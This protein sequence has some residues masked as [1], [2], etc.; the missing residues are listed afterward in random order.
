[1][2]L[3][4]VGEWSAAALDFVF[5]P[6]CLG[7]GDSRPSQN[8]LCELCGKKISTLEHPLCLDCARPIETGVNCPSCRPGMPLFVVGDH[9]GALQQMVI[10]F[11]FRQVRR[12]GHWAAVELC[13]R[14]RDRIGLLDPSALV[15]VP[16]H[17]RREYFRGFNQAE[18]FAQELGEMLDL[19]VRCDL[20]FRKKH[21]A[22]QSRISG[23]KRFEN[24]RGVFEPYHSEERCERLLLVDDVVTSGATVGELSKTLRAAGHQ[25]VGVLA[26]AHRG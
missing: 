20:A 5:P 21:R 3:D 18:L 6:L 25:V 2:N 12:V 19:D 1:M 4:T 7:C 17:S 26:M 23:P 10:A 11:K 8:L 9:V 22:V 15:P 16:L 13:G 24:V 14:Q